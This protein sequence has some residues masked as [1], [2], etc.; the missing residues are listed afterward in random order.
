MITFEELIDLNYQAVW[1]LE[2][3][4]STKKI[5][6]MDYGPKKSE[7]G[8]LWHRLETFSNQFGLARQYCSCDCHDRAEYSIDSVFFVSK[9]RLD[10]VA[11]CPFCRKQ[12]VQTSKGELWEIPLRFPPD[13]DWKNGFWQEIPFGKSSSW[14]QKVEGRWMPGDAKMDSVQ[15]TTQQGKVFIIPELSVQQIYD[16]IQSDSIGSFWHNNLKQ[17]AKEVVTAPGF[18][19]P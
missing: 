16:W 6:G 12:H 9:V 15:M 19:S 5:D 10:V 1:L 13:D 8:S 7:L 4:K 17:I 2:M 14:I 11:V 3:F 18:N